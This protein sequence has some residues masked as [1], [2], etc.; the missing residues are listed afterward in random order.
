[1]IILLIGTMMMIISIIMI[2]IIV[3]IIIIV[4]IVILIVIIFIII[5][6]ICTVTGRRSCRTGSKQWTPMGG[7]TGG[8][9]SPASRSGTSRSVSTM[10]P[11]MHA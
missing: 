6:F 8:M 1:M 4:I 7:S 2:I 10:S 9:S 5:F 3:F 11:E